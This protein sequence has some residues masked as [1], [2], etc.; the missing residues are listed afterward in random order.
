MAASQGKRCR[1]NSLVSAG[2]M[3]QEV[4]A[5]SS[6][7][8]LDL[9]LLRALCRAHREASITACTSTGTRRMGS[10]PNLIQAAAHP[11][12]KQLDLELEQSTSK[13]DSN[14]CAKLVGQAAK[15]SSSSRRWSDELEY[16]IVVT[17]PMLV[18]H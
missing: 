6:C 12:L 4:H 16:V 10:R 17:S 1:C 5:A 2:T 8:A 11:C 3:N 7:P 18:H 13:C 14:G 9:S 15:L